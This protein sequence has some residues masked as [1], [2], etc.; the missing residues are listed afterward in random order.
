MTLQ[1]PHGFSTA[2]PYVTISVGVA[3]MTEMD[4]AE[5]G[6]AETGTRAALI[7]AADRALFKA[8]AV[9]RNQVLAA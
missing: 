7:K 2:S 8:K 1:Y 9:G 5:T 4:D 3:A 6:S